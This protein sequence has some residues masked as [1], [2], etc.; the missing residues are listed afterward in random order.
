MP[1][2]KLKKLF[3]LR[4]NF[5][6]EDKLQIS[7]GTAP[8]IRLQSLISS[9]LKEHK[10]DKEGNWKPTVSELFLGNSQNE[11][12]ELQEL[13]TSPLHPLKDNTSRF[14]KRTIEE[15]SCLISVPSASSFTKHCKLPRFSGNCWSTEQP[16]TFSVSRDFKLPMLQGRFA[17]F[18]QSLRF[19]ETR[20]FICSI[21]GCSCFIAVPSKRSFVKCSMFPMISGKLSSFEQ[22]ERIRVSRDLNLQ[23]LLGKDL[24]LLQ[25]SKSNTTSPVRYPMEKGSSLIAVPSK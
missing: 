6:S 10:P 21:D 20:P 15:G 24:S 22:A 14:L 4:F 12:S 5:S 23:M 1:E 2:G 11:N 8:S 13:D 16:D 9:S 17:R 19:R 3:L 18:W 25:F 7:T